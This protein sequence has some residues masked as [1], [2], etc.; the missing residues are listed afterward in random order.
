MNIVYFGSAFN[1]PH[2]AHMACMQELAQRYDLVLAGPSRAHAFNKLMLDYE[3]RCQYTEKMLNLYNI[4]KTQLSRIEAQLYDGARPVYTFNVLTA[5]AKQ[6]PEDSITF[7]MGSDNEAIF[8]SFYNAD[9]I[10]RQFKLTICQDQDGERSTGIREAIALGHTDVV[11]RETH[12][13]LAEALVNDYQK[14]RS[15]SC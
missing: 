6:Y 2:R 10:K 13:S 3:L 9:Q 14:L 11:A 12:A 15:T 4:P 8:D 5:L 1:P 7:A